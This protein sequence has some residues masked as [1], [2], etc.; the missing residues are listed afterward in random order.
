MYKAFIIDDEPSIRSGLKQIIPWEEYGVELIGEASNGVE[1]YKFIIENV[2][3]IVICDI[4][5]PVM[6]GLELI[7]KVYE[8][9]V[10]SRFIILSGHDDFQYVKEA[11]HY[12]VENYMLK[13]I[14]KEELAQTID[15]IVTKLESDFIRH[16]ELNEEHELIRNNVLNRLIMNQIDLLEFKN[17]LTFIHTDINLLDGKLQVVVID[18]FTR[19]SDH[20][21]RNMNYLIQ[22]IEEICIRTLSADQAVVFKDFHGRIVII[23]KVSIEKSHQAYIQKCMQTIMADSPR[24]IDAKWVITVGDIVNNYKNIYESYRNSLNIQQYRLYYNEEDIIF[25]EDIKTK[26]A[27]NSKLYTVDYHHIDECI[28]MCRRSDIHDYINRSFEH[29]SHN[30]LEPEAVY[31][32]VME[33]V[34]SVLRII[35]TMGIIKSEIFDD[36]TYLLRTIHGFNDIAQLQ[37]WL[38]DKIMQTIT[39][40]EHQ[41]TTKMS[42]VI[43]DLLV[44]V[45]DH[46]NEDLSLKTYSQKIHYNA[47]YLGRLFRNETDEVFTEHVN[48]VR[49]EKSKTMLLSSNLKIAD[50]STSIGFSNS[51]YYCSIFKKLVGVTPSEYRNQE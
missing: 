37:Q 30:E 22:T 3:D 26:Q 47:I 15:Q 50:I 5:M 18:F 6:T 28:R 10:S 9:D 13:P 20:P 48:K 14:N 23:H 24:L 34:I 36:E 17:K 29:L 21:H 25:Y 7:K 16:S 27:I 44:F 38:R 19:K 4:R 2:P 40:I 49:I 33:V 41:S 1:A 32:F 43:K 42:K 8:E 31:T 45:D 51:N 11:L 12:N 46:Y 35:H 39:R